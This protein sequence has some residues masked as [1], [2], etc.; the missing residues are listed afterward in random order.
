MFYNFSSVNTSMDHRR[1]SSAL[2]VMVLLTFFIFNIFKII[3]H[4]SDKMWIHM[5]EQN[6][7]SRK[8]LKV[9]DILGRE[10]SKDVLHG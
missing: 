3:L 2:D 9:L 5:E 7:T 8:M 10:N 6:K 1:C 4:Y